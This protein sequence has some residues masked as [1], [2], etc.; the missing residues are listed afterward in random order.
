M[1]VHEGGKASGFKNSSEGDAYDDDGIS[2]F[3]IKGTDEVNVVGVQTAEVAA[4]LNS[5]DCF[6][7]VTPSH[8][9]SWH[10]KGALEAEVASADNIAKILQAHSNGPPGTAPPAREL[11]SVAEGEEPEEFWNGI[12]GK[13]EYAEAPPGEPMPSEPRLFHLTNKFGAFQVGGVR[14]CMRNEWCVCSKKMRENKIKSR[15]IFATSIRR[16]GRIPKVTPHFSHG[17]FHSW[18]K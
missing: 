13:G 2:L 5:M 12:G 6:V 17:T 8:V 11:V 10:G 18:L 3:H 1:V 7:L 16:L 14:T 15:F 9:Y 4:S